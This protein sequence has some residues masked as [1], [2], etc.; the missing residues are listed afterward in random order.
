MKSREQ[1]SPD[2]E[3]S[4]LDKEMG[5]EIIEKE[6]MSAESILSEVKERGSKFFDLEG[7]RDGLSEKGIEDKDIEVATDLMACIASI[8]KD[9]GIGG[10]LSLE[11]SIAENE[12]KDV[13][14][15]SALKENNKEGYTV[16]AKGISDN[17]LKIT[18]RIPK[19][20]SNGTTVGSYDDWEKPTISELLTSVAI[21]EVRH[22]LQD[23]KFPIIDPEEARSCN[24]S[25]LRSIGEYVGLLFEEERKQYYGEKRS[26]EYIE[27][28]TNPLEFDARVVE[29]MTL[30]K[31][32]SG[33]A[34]EDLQG[35]L[36]LKA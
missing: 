19:I 6:K 18:N 27:H 33:M 36:K 17:I 2:G 32:H 12:F 28:K 3:D 16:Y 5:Q 10:D 24:D 29:I 23:H 8:D 7:V 22:R 31:L 4:I 25:L 30:I 21:H 1:F 9:T 11:F 26:A 14:G 15:F 35:L 13:A 20:D 34:K